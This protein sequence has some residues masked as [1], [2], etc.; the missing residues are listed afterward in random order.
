M[1]ILATGEVG[2]VYAT[3]VGME[4]H[5]LFWIEEGEGVEGWWQVNPEERILVVRKCVGWTDFLFWKILDWR[6]VPDQDEYKPMSHRTDGM[7]F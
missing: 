2:K 6:I 7:L 1:K 4:V 5:K 3:Q